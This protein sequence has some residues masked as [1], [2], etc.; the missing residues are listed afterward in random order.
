MTQVSRVASKEWGSQASSETYL[1]ACCELKWLGGLNEAKQRNIQSCFRIKSGFATLGT[2]REKALRMKDRVK[3]D[4]NH[5][6]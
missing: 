5:I 4:I 2:S 6:I 1:I 3:K